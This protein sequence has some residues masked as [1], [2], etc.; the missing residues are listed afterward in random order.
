[1]IQLPTEE[2][3]ENGISPLDGILPKDPSFGKVSETLEELLEKREPMNGVL[4]KDKSNHVDYTKINGESGKRLAE[5]TTHNL[6]AKKPALETVVTNG[7]TNGQM[8]G[9]MK[10]VLPG[11]QVVQVVTTSGAQ[12]QLISGNG[13]FIQSGGQV[14][15]SS[16]GQVLVSSSGH[17]ILT[18][19]AG[20]G[21]EP[22]LIQTS[23]GQL[24][25]KTTQG[26]GIVSH[27]GQQQAGVI[28]QQ[29]PQ[30]VLLQQQQQPVI[31]QQQQQAVIVQ[32]GQQGKAMLIIPQEKQQQFIQ[33]QQQQQFA[34]QYTQPQQQIVQQVIQTSNGPQ[35]V[36]QVVVASGNSNNAVVHP[37]N[38]PSTAATTNPQTVSSIPND[39]QHSDQTQLRSNTPTP[40]TNGQS[41][42]PSSSPVPC[43]SPPPV[44]IDPGR[45]FLCEW[46]NCMKSFKTPK[47]VERHAIQEHCPLGMDEDMPCL[48]ARCDGM[49]RKRFSLMTHLQDRHCHPQVLFNANS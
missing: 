28:V 21:Q 41:T 45:P 35:L 2:I 39:Q 15:Q 36:R 20:G 13:Q 42:P 8:N 17:L 1:M 6:P 38:L 10:A 29:Q 32:Q 19:Q 18:T 4:S 46:L 24:Y 30:T 49:R 16:S 14:V 22:Q 9:N 25:L 23:S 11:G 33:P 43:P 47:E 5:D 7:F 40:L 37:S 31:V 44:K 26:S 34:Q 48:W 3:I 12:S 27:T